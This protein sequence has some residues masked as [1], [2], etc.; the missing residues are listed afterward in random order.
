MSSSSPMRCVGDGARR[1]EGLP[2]LYEKARSAAPL[3]GGG[4]LQCCCGGG[5]HVP[6]RYVSPSGEE[7]E[8]EDEDDTD[9]R[10][11]KKCGKR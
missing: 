3:S 5:A 9:G 7:D 10:R 6:G 11:L 4:E 8:D 1:G 2:V